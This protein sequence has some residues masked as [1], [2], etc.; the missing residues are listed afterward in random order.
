MRHVAAAFG[1]AILVATSGPGSGVA[2]AQIGYTPSSIEWLTASS[3]VVVRATVSDLAFSDREPE[4]PSLPSEWQHVTVTLKVLT[5]L[6][7]K[8][9]ESIMFV[10][11]QPRGVETLQAWKKS[12]QPVLWFL[13]ENV[14]DE[15]K[16]GKLRSRD[17]H[18]LD[19]STVELGSAERK[20]KVPRP[21]LTVSLKALDQEDAIVDAVKAE[22]ARRGQGRETRFVRVPISREVAQLTGRAGDANELIVPAADSPV[23]I[24][25]AADKKQYPF[26]GAIRLTVTYT[27]TSK[28]TVEL[29]ANG[30]AYGGGFP[31]ETFEVTSGASRTEYAIHA[32]DP[33]KGSVSLEP[34]KS[35]KRELDLTAVLSGADDGKE[36]TATDPLPDPF[37]RLDEFKVRLTWKSAVNINK[38]PVF[39]GPTESNAIT[40]R[41]GG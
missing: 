13:I 8:P 4:V 17:D 32:I 23:S 40:F 3:D 30:Q 16:R 36:R 7:G 24:E 34:G 10:V 33:S 19:A 27:N 29:L 18:F 22:V 38:K 9:P 12:A 39:C 20:Q 25:I 28:E 11:D 41:V 15:K 14:K 5:T 37:G 26:R 6:K 1:L 31:G 35:W 2:F 21:V